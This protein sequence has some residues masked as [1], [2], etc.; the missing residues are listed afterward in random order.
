MLKNPLKK[1]NTNVVTLYCFW[2]CWLPCSFGLFL[3]GIFYIY[4]FLLLTM[5]DARYIIHIKKYLHRKMSINTYSLVEL[6]SIDIMWS[7]FIEKFCIVTNKAI[8][9]FKGIWRWPVIYDF[10]LLIS[11]GINRE[12]ISTKA[13]KKLL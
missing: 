10:A 6:F 12:G 5:M 9:R 4:S 1:I 3:L 7:N 11:W 8:K 13:L 2:N